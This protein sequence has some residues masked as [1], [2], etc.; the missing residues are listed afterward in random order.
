MSD[1]VSDRH[2]RPTE[3]HRGVTIPTRDGSVWDVSYWIGSDG[4]VLAATTTAPIAMSRPRA[5]HLRYFSA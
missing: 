3:A 1:D 5:P 4:R 2:A